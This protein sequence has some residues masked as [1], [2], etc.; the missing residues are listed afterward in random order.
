[1]KITKSQPNAAS[2]QITQGQQ[3]AV[4]LFEKIAGL[5]AAKL[6]KK[7]PSV[8]DLVGKLEKLERQKKGENVMIP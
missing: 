7:T 3:D 6:P 1:M 4:S 2:Q 5:L 8:H